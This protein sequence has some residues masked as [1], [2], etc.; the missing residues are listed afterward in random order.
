[1]TFLT[2]ANKQ[3]K[4]KIK[5]TRDSPLHNKLGRERCSKQMKMAESWSCWHYFVVFIAFTDKSKCSRLLLVHTSTVLL[6]LIFSSRNLSFLWLT[7]TRTLLEECTQWSTKWLCA[8]KPGYRESSCELT[9]S[10]LMQPLPHLQTSG[11]PSKCS[12]S[13]AR[14]DTPYIFFPAA[15]KCGNGSRCGDIGQVF[16]QERN[17]EVNELGACCFWPVRI[18]F[19]FKLF[20]Q[21]WHLLKSDTAHQDHAWQRQQ[22]RGALPALFFIPVGSIKGISGHLWAPPVCLGPKDSESRASGSVQA[23]CSIYTSSREVRQTNLITLEASGNMFQWDL[24]L[25]PKLLMVMTEKQEG[26]HQCCTF[27]QV[28]HCFLPKK[29]NTESITFVLSHSSSTQMYGKEIWRGRND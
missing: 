19:I 8:P 28:A 15:W 22:H 26:T 11:E 6:R 16:P 29:E 20:L 12:V 2:E 24:C 23:K 27:L 10:G 21:L 1:M 13:N 3:T 18:G 25:L 14:V 9:D 4:K 7:T 17:S 5:K